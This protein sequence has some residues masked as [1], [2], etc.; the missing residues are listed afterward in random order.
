MTPTLKLTKRLSLELSK[1]LPPLLCSIG[2]SLSA[3]ASAPQFP[4]DKLI[5][6]PVG[7]QA[8]GLY[9]IT[10]FETYTVKYV[11][12][13]PCPAVFGFDDKDIPKV[14]DW[15]KDMRAYSEQHCK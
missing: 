5:E 13:I 10:N 14:L 8:C 15:M 9:Q 12:D 11:K 7:S 3:C 6:H 2:L 4:T 1:L